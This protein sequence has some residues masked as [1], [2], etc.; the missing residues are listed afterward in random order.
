MQPKTWMGTK[1]LRVRKDGH[2][3]HGLKL[4]VLFAIEPG[5]PT[6]PAEVRGSIDNP[7]R[8]I[9]CLWAVGRTAIIFRDFV[10]SICNNIEQH[11]HNGVDDHRIFMWDNLVAHHAGY[12]HETVVERVGP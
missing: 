8:W 1:I 3:G 4:T 5:D 12:V 6:L 2:Y 9:H 7:R 11:G 10:N